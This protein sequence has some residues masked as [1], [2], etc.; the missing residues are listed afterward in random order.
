[1]A[2]PVSDVRSNA[3]EQIAHAVEVLGR[4]K[5]R[6]AVFSAVYRGKK[7][8]KSVNDIA[9]STSLSRIRV[10]QEGLRLA[11]ND[12]V[13]Q[14][15]VAGGTAYR[16]YP[17]YA[18][19][20]ARILKLV[21]NQGAL[22]QFRSKTRQPPA[23]APQLVKVKL[24]VAPPRIRHLTVDDIDNFEKVRE[25]EVL[26]G[27]YKRIPEKVFKRGVARILKETGR[28]EDWGGESND[29]YTTRVHLEG[30][31]VAAA[32]AFKGPG[33]SGILTPGKMGKHGNQIQRLFRIPAEVYI[34]QYWGQISEDVTE[35]LHAFAVARAA[36]GGERICYGVING[37]DSTRLVLAYPKA[38]KK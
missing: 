32:F 34:V 38:F 25:V 31:R 12:V 4:S 15:R 6:I 33:T 22:T 35:Q 10:L 9:A 30:R 7:K 11:S 1:M 29:L 27:T 23:A 24:K 3:R 14:L 8:I 17:F 36:T 13:E 21:R 19:N 16:K 26:V 37:D 28:F 18:T 2:L 5:A 20:K